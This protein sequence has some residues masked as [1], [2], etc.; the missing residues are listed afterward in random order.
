VRRRPWPRASLQPHRVGRVII[1]QSSA[2]WAEMI[3]R[4][5]RTDSRA[6]SG[7]PPCPPAPVTGGWSSPPRTPRS[8]MPIRAIPWKSASPRRCAAWSRCGAATSPGPRPCAQEPSPS[9]APG[10]CAAPAQVAHALDVRLHS[11][12]SRGELTGARPRNLSM[13]PRRVPTA[14]RAC[15]ATRRSDALVAMASTRK[16]TDPDLRSSPNQRAVGSLWSA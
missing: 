1:T 3:S 11:P 15:P 2:R 5:S 6:V 12:P 16:V 4:A 10:L 7:S 9:G 14:R 13:P 8:A